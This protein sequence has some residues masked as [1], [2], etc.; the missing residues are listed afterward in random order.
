MSKPTALVT[1]CSRGGIG[2]AL[3]RQL[4][5]RGYH[6]FA[7][8]RNPSKAAHLTDDQDIEVV[9]LDVTSSESINSLV[10]NLKDRLPDGKLD[11]LINNAAVLL[12][13]PS[14]E[15][16]LARVKQLFDVNIHGL[17][18]VTQA[19]APMLIAAKG[20]LVNL[21]SAAGLLALPWVGMSLEINFFFI[22]LDW[23]NYL[24]FASYARL[25]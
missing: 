18:A 19:F 17:L 6:V 12:T 16:D 8:V 5:K 25:C 1:G 21:S 7:A 9:V 23:R 20:K 24:L 4:A 3:A 13:G 11:I 14:I 2:D 15:A 10:N 22:S